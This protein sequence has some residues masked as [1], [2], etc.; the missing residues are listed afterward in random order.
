[1]EVTLASNITTATTG[2][3]IGVQPVG[4]FQPLVL[5][6]YGQGVGTSGA[7]NIVFDVQHSVDGTTW[8][9]AATITV[10]GTYTSKP[11][12]YQVK[13]ERAYARVNVT[14]ITGTGAALFCNAELPC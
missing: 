7:Q 1:M 8:A 14:T 6:I 5:D 3:T 12:A 4:S 9:T 10:A 2:P 11:F 13:V